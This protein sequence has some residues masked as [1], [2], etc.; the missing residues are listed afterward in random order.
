MQRKVGCQPLTLLD[1]GAD[2]ENLEP[3]WKS[4]N[5]EVDLVFNKP[6]N[7]L[8]AGQKYRARGRFRLNVKPSD[9]TPGFTPTQILVEYCITVNLT[10]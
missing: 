4:P 9:N 5:R 10:N 7:A 2:Y 6:G 8:A 1:T 3:K